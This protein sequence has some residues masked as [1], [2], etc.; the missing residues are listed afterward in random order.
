M[1]KYVN[2]KNMKQNESNVFDQYYTKPDI[3]LYLYQKTQSVISQYDD[4]SQFTWV[5]PS[6]GEGC[7]FDILP[8]NN[9]IGIDIDPKRDDIIKHDY[10][11]YELPNKRLIVIGNPPFGHRGVLAL[12]F[13]NHSSSAEY[14]AFILPMFFK[15]TGKGSIRYRVKG[16]NLIYEE[17]LPK[18]SFYLENGKDADVKCCFQIWSKNHSV[19]SPEFSWYNNKTNTTPFEKYVSLYTVSLAKQ[20][21]CGKKW[22]FEQK[23]NWYLSSTFFKQ[24]KVVDTFDKVNYKSGIAIVY[25]TKN[26]EMIKI[27][28]SILQN[29]NWQEYAS[30]ATNGCYHI[31]K[32]NIYQLLKD[33]LGELM[34]INDIMEEIIEDKFNELN[35]DKNDNDRFIKIRTFEGNAV[36][37]I[38]ESFT[39]RVFIENNI[40]MKDIGKEVVHDEYDIISNDKKIEIKTAR[41][42]LKNNTF[43]FNGINPIYNHDYIILIGITTSDLYY[44]IISGSSI[45]DHSTRSRYLMVNSKKK[46]LVAMNPGNTVNYKLTLSV[47]DLKKI[48]G[49]IEELKSIFCN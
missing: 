25:N 34:D 49:F 38:G 18:N 24:N 30:L 47:K 44:Q 19:S 28:D 21:E 14:V 42:G 3:C 5:E 33:K 7:F 15:S 48:D 20:R 31:G 2:G 39:K 40:P 17:N 23:A 29:A 13:I 8:Q 10:L 11:T 41:K 43:Q 22:I 35:N 16:F 32:S 26:K 1:L 6:V 45:Y 4:L 27:L 12:E 46:K 37:Q 9:K 36:G